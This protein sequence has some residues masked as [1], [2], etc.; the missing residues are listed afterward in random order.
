[1]AFT[2]HGIGLMVYGERDYWPDGSFV[3]TEWFVVAYLPI[4]PIISK[5]ISYTRN[6][7]YATYNS[8]GYWVYQIL[9]NNRK[10]VLSIYLW[11]ASLL[12]LFFGWI[13][14]QTAIEMWIGDADRA[15][16]MFLA[17]FGTIL[18]L[19][20]VLRRLAK[21]RKERQW[22]RINAG[23]ESFSED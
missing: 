18:A 15:A 20:Y 12:A 22:K 10:Q 8:S 16:G 6:S 21:R 1:M 13:Y 14:F 23:L 7:D 19:P 9:P 11:F 17:T 5:R 4:A 3:T 2:F